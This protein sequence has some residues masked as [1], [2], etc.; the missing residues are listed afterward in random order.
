MSRLEAMQLFVLIADLGSFAAAATQM[1]VARSVVTRQI[2]ALE[3]HLGTKLMTRTTRRLTLTSAGQRYLEHCRDILARVELAETEVMEARGVPRGSLRVGL[4][5]DFG[6]DRLL[7]ILV[8]FSQR[9]P[10][11]ELA[12]DFTDR[13]IDL[14]KERYDLAVRITPRLQPGDVA[15]K[16]GESHLL[17]VAAP[18]YLETHG[19]PSHPEDLRHHICLGYSQDLSRTPW[20]YRINGHIEKIYPEF[21]LQAN[22]GSAL[23]HAAR[24]GLG[25]TFQPDFIVA[26]AL[27]RGEL[28]SLLQDYTPPPFG[29][30]ALLPSN[31]YMP[32]RVRLLLEA[33]A[34]GLAGKGHAGSEVETS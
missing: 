34:Q 15:R 19:V 6:L 23:C 2:A 33:F 30:Y 7:P 18:S 28:L 25:I 12:L 27:E 8:S 1:G 24:Q 5:L 17:T 16:L 31:R 11:V 14:I 3:A 13:Q 29:I 20:I 9:Y 10:E 26:A 32:L 22:N 4:P 21:K